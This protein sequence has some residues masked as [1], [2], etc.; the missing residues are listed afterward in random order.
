MNVLI[1]GGCGFIGSNLAKHLIRM[2]WTVD[3]VDNMTGGDIQSLVGEKIRHLPNG[4]FLPHFYQSIEERGEVRKQEEIL[5]I[6]DDLISEGVLSCIKNKQYDIIFHQAAVPRVSYSVEN[7][8]ETTY[9]NIS[10]TVTL[11]E[12]CAGNVSRV[13]WASSSSVSTAIKITLFSC[14]ISEAI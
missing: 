6:P 2:G 12:A 7:P 9:E 8:G 4:S 5:V 3:V 13:A 10:K 11:F 14:N 1:T